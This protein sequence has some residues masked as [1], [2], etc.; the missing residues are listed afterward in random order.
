MC[1]ELGANFELGKNFKPFFINLA[2]KEKVFCFFYPCH[3]LKLVR[4]TLGHYLK[5]WNNGKEILFNNIKRLQK[6]QDEEGL[7]AGTKLIKKH[8]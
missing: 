3:M 1:K 5:L 8:I 2:T 6:L 4:N 7:K